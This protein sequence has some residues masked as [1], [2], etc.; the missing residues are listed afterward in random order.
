[1]L[2]RNHHNIPIPSK[3]ENNLQQNLQ[4]VIQNSEKFEKFTRTR[5]DHGGEKRGVK[6]K[7]EETSWTN[8]TETLNVNYATNLDEDEKV[9]EEIE[10]IEEIDDICRLCA[11]QTDERIPIF[12]EFG[13][14]TV[15]AECI[16]LMP[17]DTIQHNDGL[18]QIACLNCLHKLDSCMNII[19]GFVNNQALFLN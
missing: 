18:P 12:N 3:F 13:E 8:E 4:S 14:L 11:K 15:E 6:R 16:S 19:N 9:K 1:M 10:Y 17:K 2:N 7:N 5:I